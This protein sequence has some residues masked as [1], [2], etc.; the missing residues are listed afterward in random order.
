MND[1]NRGVKPWA[2][3]D[4]VKDDN[5]V[6]QNLGYFLHAQEKNTSVLL[7]LIIKD[8]WYSQVFNLVVHNHH[9]LKA[10]IL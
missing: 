6:G 5:L 10:K 4:R 2:G 1:Y 7:D 9:L 8:Q 3:K